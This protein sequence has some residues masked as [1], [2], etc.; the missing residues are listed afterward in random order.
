[1]VSAA[2]QRGAYGGEY[3][4][5]KIRLR[6]RGGRRYAKETSQTRT[7]KCYERNGTQF[8]G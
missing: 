7:R 2:R 6:A 5:A 4:R 8:G 1:M 3:L